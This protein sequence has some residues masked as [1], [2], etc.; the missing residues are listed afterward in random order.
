MS[1][2]RAH[3]TRSEGESSNLGR[4]CQ[5]NYRVTVMGA[6]GV[7]KTCII[8]QFLHAKFYAK[9]KATVEEF[10]RQIFYQSD[11][12]SLVLDILDTSGAYAFPA[13]RRL[14]ISTSDAFV[15]VYS[16]DDPASFDEVKR[17][18]EQIIE[19]KEDEMTPIVIVGNKSDVTGERRALERV[20][21]ESTVNIDWNNGYVEASAKD[22]LNIGDIFNELMVQADMHVSLGS[23]GDHKRRT[24]LPAFNSNCKNDALEI[25]RKQDSCRIS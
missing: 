16:V 11:G 25:L 21:I 1:R 2:P 9:Y 19:E 12:S 7:G 18:R 13:M 3:R 10:H 17:L 8:S 14:S 20:T 4:A 23:T 22:N 15:L 24:S 5:T 6:A